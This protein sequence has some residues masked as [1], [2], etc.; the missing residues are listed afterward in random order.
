VVL[1]E[2]RAQHL[3]EQQQQAAQSN[4]DMPASAG[5]SAENDDDMVPL[6]GKP[7]KPR[8]K[9]SPRDRDVE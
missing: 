4:P 8:K 7:R 5:M 6:N 9:M 1:V 2:S 3:I